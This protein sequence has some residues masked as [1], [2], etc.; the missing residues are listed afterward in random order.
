MLKSLVDRFDLHR[1]VLSWR[2]SCV[3]KQ[4]GGE[5]GASTSYVSCRLSNT[6]IFSTER[7]E[8][9]FQLSFTASIFIALQCPPRLSERYERGG[10]KIS[11]DS[12]IRTKDFGTNSQHA[13]Q[14]AEMTDNY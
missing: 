3:L 10:G 11:V 2:R 6:P 7:N 4:F 14:V 12:R 8:R 13:N 9:K 5:L 1:H